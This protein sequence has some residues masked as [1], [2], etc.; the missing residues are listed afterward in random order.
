MCPLISP[1][2]HGKRHQF[3]KPLEYNKQ[4]IIGDKLCLLQRWHFSFVVFQLRQEAWSTRQKLPFPLLRTKLILCLSMFAT[5]FDGQGC[6]CIS[7]ATRLSTATRSCRWLLDTTGKSSRRRALRSR[8]GDVKY[9]HS[10]AESPLSAKGPVCPF[11]CPATS[12]PSASEAVPIV[13]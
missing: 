5:W 11:S 2:L 4:G 13:D 10:L 9:A 3:S 7:R 1:Y 8:V 6:R 12:G